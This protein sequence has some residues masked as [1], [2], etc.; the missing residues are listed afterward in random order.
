MRSRRPARPW[1]RADRAVMLGLMVLVGVGL[2]AAT[3]SAGYRAYRFAHFA[4]T[5]DS[6]IL[7]SDTGCFGAYGG[8]SRMGGKSTIIYT[9]EFPY[10]GGT[11]R[12]EVLRPCDIYP[13][14]FGRGRGRIWVQFDRDDPDRIR[15]LNDDRVRV[16]AQN[17]GIALVVFASITLGAV[18]VR[19]PGPDPRNRSLRQE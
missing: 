5:V 7:N 13:P 12:T 19:R 6:L 15:V 2:L 11:H 18:A 14:D 1:T 17:F 16:H 3:L 4:V 8:G 10:A 9:V